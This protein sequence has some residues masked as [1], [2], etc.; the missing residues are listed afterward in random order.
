MLNLHTIY[1]V[2]GS[3]GEHMDKLIGPVT[4]WA[5]D[6]LENAIGISIDFSMSSFYRDDEDYY[7]DDITIDGDGVSISG[8][9]DVFGETGRRCELAILIESAASIDGL[10]AGL[11]DED[12]DI[13]EL[14]KDKLRELGEEG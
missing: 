3:I 13:R 14:A 10:P 7:V 9:M 8:R 2:K 4:P 5:I 12:E 11:A 1:P 6:E